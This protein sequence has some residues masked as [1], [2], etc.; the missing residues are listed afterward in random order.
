MKGI[1]IIPAFNEEKTI[2]KVLTKIPR[3]IYQHKLDILVV[4]DGSR[5]DTARISRQYKTK[6][7]SHPINRGLG[8]A[9]ATGFD[10]ARTKKYDFLITLDAD[11]QHDPYEIKKLIKPILSSNADFVVGTRFKRASLKKYNNKPTLIFR[12][13]LTFFASLATYAFTGVWTSDSQSGFRV[14]S[15]K[16]IE[17]IKIETDRMEVSTEFF[18]HCKEKGL[19][20]IELTIKPIY[21]TYSLNK[22]QNFLNSFN[23]IG[24]LA[25]RKFLR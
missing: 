6:L 25:I 12:K 11:G 4:D 9:L 8:A 21:T 22:G 23:I 3:E 14:F 10:Y 18:R 7:V 13:I 5:D 19:R 17:Q 24:R 20:I 15:K 1:V 16:A 2:G